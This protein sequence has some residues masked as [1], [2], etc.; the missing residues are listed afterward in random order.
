MAVGDKELLKISSSCIVWSMKQTSDIMVFI[1]KTTNSKY[2][3]PG[4]F[5]K[6]F[7][8]GLEFKL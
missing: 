3:Y 1:R 5:W 6:Y 2:I 7:V 4:Y 8:T